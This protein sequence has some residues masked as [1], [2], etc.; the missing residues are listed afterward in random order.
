[1]SLAK[2]L[3]ARVGATVRVRMF[4]TPST[5]GESRQVLAM[6]QK[7][8][9]VATFK[10]LNYEMSKKSAKKRRPVI[11]IF[12]TPEAAQKAVASSPIT[13]PLERAPSVLP[14]SDAPRAGASTASPAAEEPLPE[15]SVSVPETITCLIE[16]DEGWPHF[17]AMRRNPYYLAYKAKKPQTEIY[18]DMADPTT[19]TPLKALRDVLQSNVESMATSAA[20]Q[21]LPAE[22]AARLQK[23]VRD[24]RVENQNWGAESLMG[25]HEGRTGRALYQA[26]G[27]PANKSK[28]Y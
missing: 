18:K 7:F 14:S 1:M 9:E 28:T 5:L 13:I 24:I 25:L 17:A 8:G 15:E 19:G 10:N 20:R 22:K 4:P 12:D 27:G 3:P 6:L 2:T 26:G 23:R 16:A 11:A 21:D